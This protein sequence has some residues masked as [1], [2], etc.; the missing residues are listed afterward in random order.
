VVL[1]LGQVITGKVRKNVTQVL[2][3]P[4]TEYHELQALLRLSQLPLP[5]KQPT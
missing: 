4:A 5:A 3:A 2:L 1:S